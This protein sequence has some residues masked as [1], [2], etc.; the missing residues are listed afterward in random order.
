MPVSAISLSSI[1]KNLSK[2]QNVRS[3]LARTGIILFLSDV[4]EF[5]IVEDEEFW[6]AYI[7]SLSVA[8]IGGTISDCG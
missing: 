2:L 4:S 6:V 3:Y 8:K 1:C 5:R 7:A